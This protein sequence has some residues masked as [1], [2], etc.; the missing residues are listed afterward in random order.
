MKL[1]YAR[2]STT[3][4]QDLAIQR[5]RLS[6]ERSSTSPRYAVLNHHDNRDAKVHSRHSERG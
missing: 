5:V 4:Q 6:V 3:D 2:V 1:G